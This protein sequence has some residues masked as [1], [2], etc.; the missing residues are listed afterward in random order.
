VILPPCAQLLWHELY[1]MKSLQ[2]KKKKKSSNAASHFFF[3]P[4]VDLRNSR[5]NG[6]GEAGSII[7]Q[8]IPTGHA[9]LHAE[10]VRLSEPETASRQSPALLVTFNPQLT[11][12]RWAPSTE[13]SVGGRAIWLQGTNGHHA[14]NDTLATCHLHSAER[15]HLQSTHREMA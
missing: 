5:T 8:M 9:E 4:A 11:R 10:G 12:C 13:C 15:T 7:T 6:H 1:V 2:K 14:P 3:D